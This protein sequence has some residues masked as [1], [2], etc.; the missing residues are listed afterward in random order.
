MGQTDKSRLTLLKEVGSK[1][2][3]KMGIYICDCGVSKSI[4]LSSVASGN[5]KSC[6]CLQKEKVRYTGQQSK[7]HGMRRTRIYTIWLAMKRRSY[8]QK[9]GQKCYEGVTLDPRWLKFENF[10]EDMRHGYA[11][12]LTINRIKGVKRYSKETCE[13]ATPKQQS[14]DMATNRL[15]EFGGETLCA[16]DWEERLG[17]G[18]GTLYNRLT[19]CGWSI[20]KAL[21]TPVR[22]S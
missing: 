22:G 20:E 10:F 21:T 15:I 7:T 4:R 11:D 17:F 6:G 12:D 2:G 13:W 3:H 8:R 19:K 18:Q 9:S 1:A 5:A 16:T 14:R